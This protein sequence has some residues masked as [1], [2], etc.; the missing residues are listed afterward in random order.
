MTA[1][2]YFALI[3]T[4]DASTLSAWEGLLNRWGL[5]LVMLALLCWAGWRIC[6]FLAPHVTGIAEAQKD[7]IKGLGVKLEAMDDKLDTLIERSS[8]ERG[9]KR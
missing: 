7:F 4:V 5:P 8:S 3:Q 2:V 6:S 1:D 9:G